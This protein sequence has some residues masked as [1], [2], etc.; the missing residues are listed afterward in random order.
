MLEMTPSVKK[1]VIEAFLKEDW[2]FLLQNYTIKD[3]MED[4]NTLFLTDNMKNLLRRKLIDYQITHAHKIAEWQ[5]D[6]LIEFL[7]LSEENK[8]KLFDDKV[9]THKK[10]VDKIVAAK[11]VN[12]LNNL[13]LLTTAKEDDT[14]LGLTEIEIKEK[15]TKKVI[16]KTKVAACIPRII[17]KTEMVDNITVKKIQ[18]D[19]YSNS[20]VLNGG[21]NT[22][23]EYQKV[24]RDKNLENKNKTTYLREKLP[25]LIRSTM[26]NLKPEVNVYKCFIEN[27]KELIEKTEWQIGMFGGGRT[28]EIIEKNNTTS[29]K[30]VPT[31]VAE[32][33]NACNNDVCKKTIT[34]ANDNWKEAFD[35]ITK[36]GAEACTDDKSFLFFNRRQKTTQEFYDKFKA[37]AEETKQLRNRTN[38]NY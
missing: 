23:K 27:I 20:I 28:I 18:L 32:I 24:K 34:N 30:T 19:Y 2:A 26:K 29:K 17:S 7:K 36:I 4:I 31:R 1:S 38:K 5:Q 9:E 3:I 12:E 14:I 21:S 16:G 15:D 11:T 35:T 6:L 13:D 22:Q 8:R 33:Y 37:D 25:E 10:L